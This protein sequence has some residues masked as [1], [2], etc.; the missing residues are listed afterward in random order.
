[1]CI[2]CII[3]ST[4]NHKYL[5]RLKIHANA[6]HPLG[7]IYSNWTHDAI[8]GS[9]AIHTHIHNQVISLNSFGWCFLFGFF[10]VSFISS[11]ILSNTFM[12]WTRVEEKKNGL[13]PP[14]ELSPNSELFSIIKSRRVY[15]SLYITWF[16]NFHKFRFVFF[17][18]L[19][20]PRKRVFTNASVFFLANAYL[21]FIVCIYV[22]ESL[23]TANDLNKK[24][25]QW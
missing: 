22:L 19:S 24:K 15:Y 14:Y 12:L 10:S 11:R 3:L 25:K 7:K 9:S 16:L 13:P 8:Q 18:V 1:M 6:Y 20:F 5:T 2:V 23:T 17:F 4:P 21:Q